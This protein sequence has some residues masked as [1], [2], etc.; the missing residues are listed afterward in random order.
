M[1]FPLFLLIIDKTK[2][3]AFEE[4]HLLW[5]HVIDRIRIASL[6]WY[7]PDQVRGVRFYLLNSVESPQNSNHLYLFVAVTVPLMENDA[8]EKSP[9]KCR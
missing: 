6:R 3:D 2:R 8:K 5:S 1:M 4:K 7:E 9:V